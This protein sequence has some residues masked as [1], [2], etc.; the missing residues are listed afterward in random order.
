MNGLMRTFSISG[1]L[2]LAA[3]SGGNSS[4]QTAQAPVAVQ[5]AMPARQAFH[6][7]VEAY[8]TLSGD[9]RRAQALTLP[10]AGQ[11]VAAEVTPG[12]RVRKGQPLLRIA[13]DP[14]TVS[15]YQQAVSTVSQAR[16][17]LTRTQRLHDEKL[18]T[19]SQLDAARK[20]LADAQSALAAQ[21]KLGGAQA[22]T[23]LEA[24]ADGVVTALDVQLGERVAAGAKLIEFTPQGGLAA[25]LGVEP[26]QAVRIHSGMV[27]SLTAVYGN[28]ALQGNVVSVADAVDPQSHLVEVLATVNDPAGLAAGSALSGKIAVAQFQAWAVPRDALLNDQ[29]GDYLLQIEHGKAQRVDVRIVSPAGDPVGVDG[30]L[31][32]HAP[33]ITL[34][35]YEL[36]DGDAVKAQKGV[37][38]NQ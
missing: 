21:A 11:I 10:Q 6:S 30:K 13:T 1:L 3:C 31:D 17:E 12:R 9:T 4:D 36:S 35:A 5:T 28:T 14:N 18:A 16:A 19:N 25:L 34:G 37:G 27:A 29:A 32:A 7:Y 20:A 26:Q 8:G 23:T 22:F 38:T 33:V 24:P 2:I 15:A